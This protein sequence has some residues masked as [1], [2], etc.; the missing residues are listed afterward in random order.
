MGRAF[1]YHR[2]QP[3]IGGSN[4]KYRWHTF[5]RT[6]VRGIAD[7]LYSNPWSLDYRRSRKRIRQKFCLYAQIGNYY[8]LGALLCFGFHVLK[9]S[10]IRIFSW[11]LS[12]CPPLYSLTQLSHFWAILRSK[13]HNK[14]VNLRNLLMSSDSFERKPWLC[15]LAGFSVPNTFATRPVSF[16]K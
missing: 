6:T 8:G 16:A 14:F 10:H 3:S 11:E 7:Y 9:R 2:T 5:D 12:V 15:R 1:D 4:S 13:R